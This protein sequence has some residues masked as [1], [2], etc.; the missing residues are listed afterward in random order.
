MR[1]RDCSGANLWKAVIWKKRYIVC[2]SVN[3]REYIECGSVWEW[4]RVYSCV[5]MCECE[6]TLWGYMKLCVWVWEYMSG[7]CIRECVRICVW[8]T[9]CVCMCECQ[10]NCVRICECARVC[11][12]AR[13]LWEYVCLCVCMGVRVCEKMRVRERICENVGACVSV[14]VCEGVCECV[15][16]CNRCAQWV[17]RKLKELDLNS[18][19]GKDY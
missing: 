14:S 7:I 9:I 5:C 11:V 15:L 13:A 16:A 8:E 10:R 3:V 4:V 17:G 12:S 6:R 1:K 18:R 2:V 19:Q